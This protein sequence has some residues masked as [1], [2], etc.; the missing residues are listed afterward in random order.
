[1]A[2]DV[3]DSAPAKRALPTLRR[4]IRLFVSSTFSDMK[5]ERDVL[6]KDV[7]PKL[8]QLCLSNGLRFQPI[9]LRW[10]VPEEAGKDNRTMRICLREL[11]RCQEARPKPNFLVL[12]GDRYGWQPLPEIIP[13]EPFAQL[14]NRLPA[15]MQELFEWRDTQP[16]EAKGWYRR[17]DNAVPPVYELRPRGDDERWHETVS[18]PLL[19]ALEAAARQIG[20]DA[21]T[22]GVAIGASATEQEIIEG[23]LKIGDAREHVHAFFRSISGLPHDP[24]AQDFVDVLNDGTRDPVAMARLDDLKTRIE[25]KVGATNVHRYTVPWHEDG[26]QPAD[27]TQFGQEVYVAL[28]DV[29]LRQIGELASTSREVQEEEAH[30]AFGD[31]RCR[32]F[33]GRTEPLEQIA[34]CLQGGEHGMLAVVGS[35]GS[36]KSAVMAEAVRRA[37]QTYGEDAVLARFIGATPHSANVLSLLGNLVAEI[38][39][40]YPAPSPAP[41]EKSKDGEIPVEINPLTAAFHEALARPAVE[42]PLFVFLDALDQLAPGNGAWEGHW[43]PG[44]LNPH[45]RLIL[46]TALPAAADAIAGGGAAGSPRLLHSAQDPRA[47]VMATLERRASKVQ[48]IRLQ[49]LSAADGRTLVAQWLADAGRTL[50]SAQEEG[51][52]RSFAREGNPLWL[53]VAVNESRRLASWDTAPDFDADLPELLRQVLD[54]LSAEDEHGTV[55]VERALGGIASARHGLAEDEVIDVL[56][57]DKG[58]MADFRRRSPKSPMSNTLPVAVWVRLHGDIAPYLA[59]RQ[60]QNAALLGFYHR[61]FLETAQKAFLDTADRQRVAHQRLADY[62][63]ARPSWFIAPADQEASA[64]RAAVITDPPDARRV[65]DLPWQLLRVASASDPARERPDAWDAPVAVLCDIEFVEAKCRAGLVFELQEDYR[66]ARTALP[67]AQTIIQ[68]EQRREPRIARWT[69][70]LIRYA[71]AWSMRRD[72]VARGDRVDEAEPVLPEPPQ[73]CRMWADEEIE[74]ECRRIRELPTRLDRLTAFAG[75]VQGECYPL[76]EFGGR[77]GFAV[78]HALSYAPGGP[79]HDA[80][81]GLLPIAAPLLLRRWSEDATWNPKPAILRT[82]EAYRGAVWGVSVTPDGLRALSASSDYTL[83]V[84]DLRSG[85]CLS[86]LEGHTDS[87]LS[88]SA[89]PDGRRAVSGSFDKTL[90]VWDLESGTCLQA[91]EGHGGRVWSVSVTPD[92]RRSVSGSEDSTLRVWDLESGTCLHT[93]HAHKGGVW[94]VSVT[95]DGRRAVSGGKDNTVRVWDLESGACLRTLEGHSG[96]VGSVSVAPDGRRAVSGSLSEWPGDEGPENPDHTLRVWDLE[97]GRCERVLEGHTSIPGV[98]VTPDGRRA[99]SG[100]FDGSLRV[101]DLDSGT[102]RRD[103]AG[104]SFWIWSVSVT[105]DGRHAVSGSLDKTM[106]L[107]DLESSAGGR[108]LGSHSV[109]I[110]SLSV[111]PDGRH[112]ISGSADDEFQPWLSVWDLESG[113]CERKLEIHEHQAHGQKWL[114]AGVLVLSVTADGRHVVSG[115]DDKLRVWDLETGACLRTLNGHTEIVRSVSVTH[116][117]RRAVSGSEDNTLRVWDLESGACLHILESHSSSVLCVSVTPDGRRAVSGSDDKTLRVWDLESGACLHTLEGHLADVGSVSVTPDGRRAVSGSRDRVLRVWNLETGRCERAI[118][119]HSDWI[120]SVAVTPDGRWAIAGSGDRTVRVWDLV[121][122]ACLAVFVATAQVSAVAISQG[123]LTVGTTAGEVLF[124]EM[125]N[126]ATGP[127]IMQDTSDEAHEALLRRSLD[128]SR[129]EKGPDHEET[130]A[131]LTALAVLL[132]RTGEADEARS[133]REQRGWIN[134]HVGA[135]KNQE[136]NEMRGGPAERRAAALEAYRT[137]HYADAERLLRSLIADHFEVPSMHCHLVRILLIQDRWKEG[138]TEI[139][140]AWEDRAQA[141]VYVVP[142]ILWLQLALI[143]TAPAEGVG[144]DELQMHLGQVILGQLKTALAR[145]G[146]H[147]EWA[148][149]PVLEHL[150]PR[151]PAEHYQLLAALVAALRDATNLPVLEQLPAWRDAQPQP[152]ESPEFDIAETGAEVNAELHIYDD[153]LLLENKNGYVAILRESL[154]TSIAKN[155]ATPLQETAAMIAGQLFALRSGKPSEEDAVMSGNEVLRKA[156]VS[157]FSRISDLVG[158]LTVPSGWDV[159]VFA[160]GWNAY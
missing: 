85:A 62:F 133:L 157:R 48:Q 34:A 39:R 45:V 15:P 63:N 35:P 24:L 26:V 101:W 72:R 32:G 143:H 109:W 14:R 107:W 7:F 2:D 8:R 90:R 52:L 125:N 126:L 30:R 38:R 53:R 106:R 140:A 136:R 139:A 110:W 47:V 89:T 108:A 36:G 112:V 9:D 142:R 95:P 131:H 123:L 4:T 22:H 84:W 137:G 86:T 92:G 141:P 19:H 29:I 28:R 41:G 118:Q 59:E 56:S 122:G 127:T 67:E 5:V 121:S 128:R 105:P 42:R 154:V 60:L 147:M 70:E 20:L 16:L 71:R 23:A 129:R 65:S 44:A 132:E 11:K 46:S 82:L 37:R 58:I 114:N 145:E 113:R 91:L 10:G 54:R 115:G 55:L 3:D 40:R 138:I 156:T 88:V 79:L 43:L 51:I 57:A 61:S 150:Q 87:V 155:T 83:R 117:G 64:P 18:Q 134:P 100:S 76:V 124:V 50:Q 160:V 116:D 33:I 120:S 135:G 78:Q 146:A 49:L 99:V 66:D 130:L 6:Q 111:T 96:A 159:P 102:C 144:M 98:S 103:L 69:D 75:F 1:M 151:L 93:L 80:A 31:E 153:L 27:L 73:A 77:E 119:G 104:H 12:L 152:L 17:D 148:M 74:A 97:N 21:A 13:A 25:T 94:S 149:D 81:R 158:Q 68:E